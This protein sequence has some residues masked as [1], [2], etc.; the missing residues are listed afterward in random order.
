MER[1]VSTV[2]S[3]V[4]ESSTKMKMKTAVNV[5]QAANRF[6]EPMLTVAITL[7]IVKP[8]QSDKIGVT[9]DSDEAGVTYIT[10]LTKGGLFDSAGAREGDFVLN[11][12]G[13][14]VTDAE[15]AVALLGSAEGR[16]E[17]LIERSGE[18][19]I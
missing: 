2:S 6:M 7:V 10:S 1:D 8:N 17:V 16:F 19:Q 14:E 13:E 5:V 11:I 15:M 3:A 12:G 4:S 9:M 18:M